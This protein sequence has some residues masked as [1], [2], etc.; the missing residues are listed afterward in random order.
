MEW[1][2][3]GFGFS[4]VKS[5]LGNHVKYYELCKIVYCKKKKTTVHCKKQWTIDICNDQDESSEI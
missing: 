4:S 3:S 2:S 5:E 1:D